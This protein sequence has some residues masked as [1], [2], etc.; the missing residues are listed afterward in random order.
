[1]GNHDS[2]PLWQK[3]LEIFLEKTN[4]YAIKN[5]IDH[6]IV[7]SVCTALQGCKITP[8]DLDIL[9]L[10]PEYVHS[11]ANL[12][13]KYEL[14]QSPTTSLMTIGYHLRSNA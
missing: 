13:V 12:M 14:E 7:G 2:N 5:G 1:M 11:L 9:A 10:K 4:H 3:G 6:I 8:N